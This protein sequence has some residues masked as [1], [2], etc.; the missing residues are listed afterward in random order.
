MAVETRIYCETRLEGHSG[1]APLAEAPSYMRV[2]WDIAVDYATRRLGGGGLTEFARTAHTRTYESKHLVEDPSAFFLDYNRTRRAVWD[3]FTRLKWL[4]GFH[5]SPSNWDVF[6]PDTAASS[7]LQIVQANDDKGLCGGHYRFVVYTELKVT[8]VYSEPKALLRHCREEVMQTMED[9][10][11]GE[12]CGICLDGLMM[13]TSD[14]GPVN[15]PCGHAF[16]STC[17]F[18]WFFK[19]T[20]CPIC[21]H[22][23]RGLVI[24]LWATPTSSSAQADDG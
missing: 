11:T 6:R 12:R 21:R 23:L 3:E 7:I 8:L 19:G 4:L 1:T 15:L 22:D 13:T 20:A 16:H 17:I 18:K 10:A 24:D 14:D 9:S 2:I 5:L